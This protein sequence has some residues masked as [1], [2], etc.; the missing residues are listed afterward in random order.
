MGAG[1]YI[2]RYLGRMQ[3]DLSTLKRH[4]R[5]PVALSPQP[6][7]TSTHNQSEPLRHQET[8][9]PVCW[10]PH[11]PSNTHLIFIA[12]RYAKIEKVGQY[13]IRSAVVTLDPHPTPQAKVAQT[14]N[15]GRPTSNDPHHFPRNLRRRVQGPR[16]DLERNRRPQEDPPRSR[17]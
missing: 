2:S 7:D 1:D 11:F 15:P 12:C 16:C 9:G 10:I 4:Q 6:P 13:P 17:R 8:H 14:R 3:I 5:P